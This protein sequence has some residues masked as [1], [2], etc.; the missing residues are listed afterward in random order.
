[1][2]SYIF[3]SNCQGSINTICILTVVNIELDNEFLNYIMLNIGADWWE[4]EL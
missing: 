1:M 4:V 3:S 2:I